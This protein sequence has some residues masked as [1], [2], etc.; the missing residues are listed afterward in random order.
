M[1]FLTSQRGSGSPNVAVAFNKADIAAIQV[2]KSATAA[3]DRAQAGTL[4]AS[5]ILD[6]LMGI[7]VSAK[8]TLDAAADVPGI[9][10]YSTE[11]YADA[12]GYNVATQFAAMMAEIDTTITFFVN[13]Y[14]KDADGNL[15][16]YSFNADGSGNVV[17]YNGFSPAQRTAVVNRLNSLLAT[18]D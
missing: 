1:A 9:G 7:L 2:K 8:A 13:N 5:D 18:I 17:S 16:K 15:K 10:A 4:T 6:S 3:R 11:Q 14:P 12:A